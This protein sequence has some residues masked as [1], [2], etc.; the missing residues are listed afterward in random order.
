MATFFEVQ[1]A[2]AERMQAIA[3]LAD[4]LGYGAAAASVREQLEAMHN[5]A[6]TVVVAGEIKRGK[7]S[8][9]NALLNETQ[10]VCPVDA[11]VCTNT[12]TV[13]RYGEKEQV[14][15]YL[16]DK[17]AENGVRTETISRSQIGSYASESGNPGNYKNVLQIEVRLPNPLLK[18]GVVFVD[19]P[20]VGSLNPAHAETTYAY[21]P[22]ADMLLFVSDVVSPMTETELKFLERGYSYCD[23]VVFPLTKKD[24]GDYET[25]LEGNRR[26][27][28][29]TLKVPEEQVQII[30]VS[31]S[32]KLKYLQ[33]PNMPERPRERMY[34]NSN[35]QQLENTIWTTIANR[36]VQ[37]RILPYLCAAEETLQEILESL[38]NQYQVLGNSAKAK[39]MA[40]SLE[41]SRKS[42]ALLQEDGAD[43]KK[44][45]KSF[46][47]KKQ[48]D[49]IDK[50]T[51]IKTKANNTVSRRV[52]EKKKA[53]CKAEEYNAL[54]SDIN[55]II[56]GGILEIRDDIDKDI[57]DKIS[58]L[59][60]SMQISISKDES[61]L[62]G[63]R[64]DPS[65]TIDIDIAKKK[66]GQKAMIKA[67]S[68]AKVTG[69]L[70]AA[71]TALGAIVGLATAGP[72]GAM[73]GAS[74]G[75]KVG[76]LIGGGVGGVAGAVTFA[77]T[78]G[79]FD[80]NDIDEVEKKFT[81]HIK[82][83][84]DNAQ[85]KI[86]LVLDNL[87]DG[88]IA[89]LDKQLQ[90]KVLGIQTDIDRIQANMSAEE[91]KLPL[92]KKGLEDKLTSARE[93]LELLTAQMEELAQMSVEMELCTQS[94]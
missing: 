70:I 71:G 12:V 72:A 90:A 29:Q 2:A 5:R 1:K 67:K 93:Q 78:N 49:I 69:P 46:F 11:A 75:A 26:K 64:S 62:A 50:Q 3:E 45:L 66:L 80:E 40:Q 82:I 51:E 28:S 42:L 16:A 43:W 55:Q 47:Q 17:D 24:T 35:Y 74:F 34:R 39:E 68:I 89:E 19:T 7:S 9:L 77:T 59:W 79:N 81:Q 54:L 48:T 31:S 20:G 58:R 37:V 88:I 73:A 87:R 92:L 14:Q 57:T 18:E 15:V 91:E 83:T 76:G 32:A 61:A 27:I 85:G 6:L 60:S 30:P 22:N 94:V 25:I 10:P 44:H 23:C 33:D 56:S 63:V 53:I 21:L 84:L 65:K 86:K 13:L 4:K 41:R 8:L 52:K 36:Q 38:S